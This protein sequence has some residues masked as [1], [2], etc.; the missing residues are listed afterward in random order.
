VIQRDDLT[1]GEARL[2]G[3]LASLALT[4]ADLDAAVG[5]TTSTPAMGRSS[6]PPSMRLS[7]VVRWPAWDGR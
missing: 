4:E 7:G 5:R 2:D 3:S 1:I 6:S